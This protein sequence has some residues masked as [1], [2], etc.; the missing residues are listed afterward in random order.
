MGLAKSH[1]IT[2]TFIG[3]QNLLVAI[4]VAKPLQALFSAANQDGLSIRVVSGFRSFDQ[5]LTIWNE[6]WQGFRPVY[7]RHGRPLN[8]L[9]LSDI[10]KYKAISLWSALPGYSRHHWG[11]D[12]DIF[13]ADAIEAGHKVEL[14]PTEFS[15]TGPCCDLN[16][17]LKKNLSRFG[18]FRPYH[19][20]NQGV[21]E[22]PWHISFQ[23][24]ASQI[25]TNFDHDA[26]LSYIGSSNIKANKFIAEQLPHYQKQYFENICEAES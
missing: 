3:E 15:N 4:E 18:F 11:T 9:N 17:W 25:L 12:F 16:L 23:S 14:T 22:E 7:S 21:S 6:K 8:V 19:Q 24:A 1:L 13:S 2:E 5:Q 20:F 26:A 10:E